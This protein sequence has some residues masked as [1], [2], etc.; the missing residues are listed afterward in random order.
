MTKTNTD[1]RLEPLLAADRIESLSSALYK[2]SDWRKAFYNFDLLEGYDIF[3]CRIMDVRDRIDGL[4]YKVSKGEINDIP[5]RE[6]RTI[7]AGLRY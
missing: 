4:K 6:L 2:A 1:K 5:E 3:S 7:M